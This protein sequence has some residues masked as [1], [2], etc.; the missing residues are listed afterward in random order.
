MVASKK[1]AA[2]PQENGRQ[3]KKKRLPSTQGSRPRGPRAVIVGQADASARQSGVE[4]VD[5]VAKALESLGRSLGQNPGNQ[6]SIQKESRGHP[7]ALSGPSRANLSYGQGAAESAAALGANDT[8]PCGGLDVAT[9]R[10]C[11][12]NLP[13]YLTEAKLREHF[14]ARGGEVTDVKVARTK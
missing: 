12:K 5:L 8:L 6:G 4:K 7:A 2:M 9:S 14:S 11:V 13:K 3:K 10:L 1:M